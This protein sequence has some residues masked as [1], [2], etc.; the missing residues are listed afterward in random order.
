MARREHPAT[1]AIS[2][3]IARARSTVPFM[4]WW[5]RFER[6]KLSTPHFAEHPFPSVRR[7][8]ITQRD[9]LTGRSF[10]PAYPDHTQAGEK[11]SGVGT[12]GD[13]AGGGGLISSKCR[14]IWVLAF[15]FFLIHTKNSL[16]TSLYLTVS[17]RGWQY[18]QYVLLSH[19]NESMIFFPHS[20]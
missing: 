20:Y 16:V 1:R 5:G 6:R 14:D 13:E 8:T 18:A 3:S 19:E 17:R 7:A 15:R 4:F 12:G 2:I 9:W 10:C 11:K